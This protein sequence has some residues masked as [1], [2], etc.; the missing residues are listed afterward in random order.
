MCAVL[1]VPMLDG[2]TV[3]VPVRRGRTDVVDRW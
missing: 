3:E 1:A 2:V